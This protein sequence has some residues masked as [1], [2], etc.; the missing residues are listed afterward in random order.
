MPVLTGYFENREISDFRLRKYIV[1]EK[2]MVEI[3]S[4]PDEDMS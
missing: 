1:K 3:I 2:R 4:A